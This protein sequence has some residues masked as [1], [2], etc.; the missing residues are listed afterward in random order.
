[1]YG[2]MHGRG[3]AV[4]I[5]FSDLP[6]VFKMNNLSAVDKQKWNAL[7]EKHGLKLPLKD[8][9]PAK[10]EWWHVEPNDPFGGKRGDAGLRGPAY[11][12][13]IKSRSIAGGGSLAN[14]ASTA[15]QAPATQGTMLAPGGTPPAAP[16]AMPSPGG[17][18]AGAPPVAPAVAA[19]SPNQSQAQTI[20][21][22]VSTGSIPGIVAASEPAS[23]PRQNI[24]AANIGNS[25]GINQALN[26]NTDGVAEQKAAIAQEVALKTTVSQTSAELS[27]RSLTTVTDILGKS[28]ETQKSMDTKLETLVQLLRSKGTTPTPETKPVPKVAAKEPPKPTTTPQLA[29]SKPMEKPTV[30]MARTPF[31]SM[32]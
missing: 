11:A 22:Q 3:E 6:S 13:H 28:L 2:S 24:P 10:M 8:L 4:D 16:G 20:R 27:S 19:P 21:T 7:V 12:Q 26:R 25:T 15:N 5:G 31:S 23:S 17:A 14:V 9:P 29:K 32:T 1:M 30:E 18:T